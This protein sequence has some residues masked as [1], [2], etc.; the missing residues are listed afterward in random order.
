VTDAR[1]FD[2]WW[3]AVRRN[4]PDLLTYT[5]DLLVRGDDDVDDAFP[6]RWTFGT[7]DAELPLT[8]TF[9]P[10]TST[11]GITVEV[12]VA[13][14]PQVH[15]DDFLWQVPG[16]REEVVTALIRGLP[17]NLRTSFVP[18]PDTARAVL[19][20]LDPGDR[21]L[22]DALGHELTRMT[23]VVVPYDAWSP[24]SLPEHLRVTV[25]VVD[26]GGAVLGEGKEVEVLQRELAP[27]VQETISH[28]SSALERRGLTDFPVD[29]VPTFVEET[30]GEHVVRGWPA[31][32]ASGA[33]GATGGGSATGSAEDTVDLRVLVTRDEQQVAMRVGVR[34]LLR[35][36]TTPPLRY[37]VGVLS[38]REKIALGAAPHGSVP[39]L[40]ED[41]LAAC[42]D[43]AVEHAAAQD[44]ATRGGLGFHDGLPFTR[45]AYDLV[46]AVAGESLGDD[47]L[48][49]VRRAATV[50]DLATSARTGL[51]AVSSPRLAHLRT[52]VT[53][54]LDSLLPDGFITAAG[55]ARLPDLARY[56]RA[57]LRRIE[58]APQDT[59]RDL[60]RQR[61][62]EAITAQWHD[63]L[64]AL[65]PAERATPR[66]LAVRWMIEELRV[67]LFAQA[68]G[69][70]APVSTTRIRKALD[71]LLTAD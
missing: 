42:L 31:L 65:H 58:T 62:I 18:V 21:G 53:G 46:G 50:L 27:A 19:T 59:A 60:A 54:Q 29:G 32:V 4:A 14:L 51:D 38:T 36:G 55:V 43:A 71:A 3:K 67:N 39:L 24:G 45:A 6:R 49:A 70:P 23:G 11:D 47:L 5:R 57:I 7:F 61:E 8:Y 64:D 22:L 52:D 25:R 28:A 37:V 63:T 9:E 1:S 13:L 2:R 44:A 56:V 69:T 16:R 34:R 10:G 15:P 17:K 26:D 33:G 20:R 40:V 66:A 35:R 30:H 48:A 41:A 12:P 68:L